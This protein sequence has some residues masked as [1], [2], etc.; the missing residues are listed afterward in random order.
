MFII[1]N[2]QIQYFIASDESQLAVVIARSIRV[3]NGARVAGYSDKDLESMVKIGMDR[4]RS[5][6]LIRAEDIAAFV[7]VMFEVAPRFDEQDEIRAVLA[8][9]KLTPE[10]RFSMLFDRV[11]EEAWVSAQ[12]KYEDSF[13][14]TASA[15]G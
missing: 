7:A 13:W 4:A 9:T 5:H 11:S 2:K 14:F 10:M 15:K 8:D 3:A 1:K 6:D 12:K